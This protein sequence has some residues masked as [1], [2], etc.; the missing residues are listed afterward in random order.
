[1]KPT[2][3]GHSSPDPNLIPTYCSSGRTA[4]Y[5]QVQSSVEHFVTW[6]SF[7]G[8]KLLAQR[9]KP[10]AGESSRVGR[11]RLPTAHIRSCTLYLQAVSS[12]DNL[13]LC[14]VVVT[15]DWLKYGGQQ[16]W[17]D[18]TGV[19]QVTLWLDTPALVTHGS[20]NN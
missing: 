2:D 4:K 16:H 8:G 19:R 1:M 7:Y 15:R 18:S 17:Q 6:C 12:T 20:T 3:H 5:D 14:H 9:L 11:P 10:Q 13:R